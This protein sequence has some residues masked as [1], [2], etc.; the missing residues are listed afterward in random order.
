MYQSIFVPLDGS[1]FSARA[2]PVAAAFARRTGAALHLAVVFDPSTFIRFTPGDLAAPAFDQESVDRHCA[3]ARSWVEEQ[4]ASIANTGLIATGVLLEGT[5]VEALAEHAVAIHA[6]LVIMTTHGRSGVDRLWLGSVAS[7]FLART[8]AP[9]FLVRPSGTEAPFPG[10]ELPSGNLLVPLDG[11]VFSEAVLPHAVAFARALSLHIE[12]A[13]VVVPMAPPPTLFGVD[14]F[15]VDDF[16]TVD[17]ERAARRYLERVAKSFEPAP[18][19]TILSS[20]H[21]ARALITHARETH[22]AAIALATHG[23]SGIAR[24]V[25]GSVADKL[26]RGAEAPLLVVHPGTNSSVSP[27]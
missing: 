26:L 5:V 13:M 11:S 27:T 25:A 12:L 2:L 18:F 3:K 9:V 10:H 19:V 4:A 24:L 21:P 20:M 7:S 15:L 22:P 23:R 16:V 14:S 17:Q 6:D 8:P 1:D